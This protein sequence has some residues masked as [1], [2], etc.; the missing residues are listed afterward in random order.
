MLRDATVATGSIFNLEYD[1]DHLKIRGVDTESSDAVPTS[2]S[3]GDA[4]SWT[5]DYSIVKEGWQLCFCAPDVDDCTAA[6]KT[7]RAQAAMDVATELNVNTLVYGFAIIGVGAIFYNAYKLFGKAE[8]R[9][10]E[11]AEV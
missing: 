9:N 4:I 1:Y 7:T 10:I 5:S 8:Y 11:A 2:L 6:A 3:A